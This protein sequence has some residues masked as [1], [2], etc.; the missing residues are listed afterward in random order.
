[1]RTLAR[2]AVL[3]CLLAWGPVQAQGYS[4]LQKCAD[5]FLGLELAL[6]YCTRAIKSGDLSAEGA[7]VAH[8]NRG[9]ILSRR[10]N[11]IDRALA[12]FDEAV[13]LDPKPSTLVA[14]GALRASKRNY[15]DA[16]ADFGEAIRMD[17]SLAEAHLQRGLAWARK[18]ESERAIEDATRA[19][20][21]DPV[22]PILHNG[23][24]MMYSP[25]PRAVDRRIH[26]ATAY[27]LRGMAQFQR[28]QFS[29]A[30]A[31]LSETL[32]IAPGDSES[33]LWLF[34]ARTRAG[35]AAEASAQLAGYAKQMPQGSWARLVSSLLL[36][37]ST[38]QQLSAAIVEKGLLRQVQRCQASF[39]SGHWRLMKGESAAAR[40]LLERAKARC[41][42]GSNE[43]VSA[44]AELQRLAP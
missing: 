22:G 34:M 21:L 4:F 8:Y 38:P 27:K 39:Y 15:D 6:D 31:D 37:Q 43:F 20:K 11:G 26:D 9:A 12:D 14:R 44:S 28:A 42:A 29:A 7:A 32:R 5:T 35:A 3:A 13:R 36:D 2:G 23:S 18:G 30:S 41:P 1:M 16:V 24:L 25:R 40:T 10:R 17:D 19:L 33:A